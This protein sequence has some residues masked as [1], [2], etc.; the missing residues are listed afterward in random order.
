MPYKARQGDIIWL[1]LDPQA[2]HEQKGRRPALV[3]SNNTFNDFTKSAAMVC[4]ITNTD[5]DMPI[6]P[7][8][9]DRTKT[10][11]V[12]MCD[13]AKILDINVRKAEFIEKV[14]NDIIFSVADIMRSFVEVE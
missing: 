6:Q 10:S 5:R 1:N 4:P 14:P 2:G 3:I 7:K 9:D 11:G 8:L 12:I 13:Q